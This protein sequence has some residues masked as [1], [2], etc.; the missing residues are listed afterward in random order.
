MD[1]RP[2]QQNLKLIV[3]GDSGVGK[4]C[5]I[6]VYAAMVNLQQ[7]NFDEIIENSGATVGFDFSSTKYVTPDQKVIKLNIWDT[8]GQEK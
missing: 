7:E 3:L 5:L 1:D 4:S 8:A 6:Q 2:E